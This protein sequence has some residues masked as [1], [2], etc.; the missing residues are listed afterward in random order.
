M[1]AAAIVAALGGR[2]HSARCPVCADVGRDRKGNNLS[3]NER[4]GRVLVHCFAGCDQSNV[5]AAL[6]R[7][8]LWPE[9]EPGARTHHERRDWARK[10]EEA[11]GILAYERAARRRLEQ[12]KAEAIRECR[13]NDLTALSGRLFRLQSATGLVADYRFMRGEACKTVSALMR[14]DAE[15]EAHA[16]FV[17]ASVVGLLVEAERRP[18]G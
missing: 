6:R 10:N 7:R 14:E 3:V 11:E 18:N 4:D 5:I 13:W 15:D 2:H 1:S 12:L 16:R 8:G 9:R 17:A